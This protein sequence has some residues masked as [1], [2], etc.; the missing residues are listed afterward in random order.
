[1]TKITAFYAPWCGTCH[2][3][4]PKVEA[5]ARRNGMMFEKVNVEQCKTDTCESVDF[6]PH[7]LVDGRP[8]SD[9]QLERIIDG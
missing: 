9:A 3:I 8:M 5:Y 6:V 4:L 2:T 1:M 7:I